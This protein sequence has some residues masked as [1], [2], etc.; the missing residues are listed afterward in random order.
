M[1]LKFRKFNF[2]NDDY[3]AI[4][5][6]HKTIWTDSRHTAESFKYADVTTPLAEND[7]LR[8][9]AE[10]AGKPVGYGIYLRTFNYNVTDQYYVAFSTHPDYRRRGI[11]SAYF[12][13]LQHELLG[14]R[15]VSSLVTQTRSDQ[16]DAVA[17]LQKRGFELQLRR[18]RTELFLDGF[19]F[20][21]F[22]SAKT[23]MIE[24]GI[25]IQPL[26]EL[27]KVDP[28]YQEK[29][30]HLEWVTQI[31]QPQAER[32]RR[33]TLAE[34]VSRYINTPV[35]LPEGWFVATDGDRYVGWSAVLHHL[36]R[37]D[38]MNTGITVVDRPYRRQGIATALKLRTIEYGQQLGKRRIEATNAETNPMLQLNLQLGFQPIYAW[39]EY[40]RAWF[41]ERA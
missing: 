6:I 29:L 26:S 31:D 40:K 24:R 25:Q 33:K 32:P 7:W 28:D 23:K 20:M 37:S 36:N 18:I 2:S 19:D 41:F 3:K 30:W 21:R 4:F 15:N 39:L 38:T 9:V 27:M 1:A 22:A 34:F 14:Q 17:F 16:P 10:W 12:D 13:K 11:A 35:F 8:L 5:K